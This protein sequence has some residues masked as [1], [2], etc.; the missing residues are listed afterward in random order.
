MTLISGRDLKISDQQFDWMVDRLKDFVAIPS[1]SNPHAVG[2]DMLHLVKASEFAHTLLEGIGFEARSVSI[3]G[4]APFIIG[5]RHVA[6]DKPTVVVYAHYNVQPVD[7]TK[8]DSNPFEMVE[9]NGRYYGRGASDDKAGVLAACAAFKAY[10]EAG[11]E[12]P[13]NVTVLF[14]GEEEYGSGHMEALLKQEAERLR[15]HALIILDGMNRSVDTGTLTSSNRGIVNLTVEIK[16]L[17][18]PVHSGQG[19]L[20]P[21]PAQALTDLITRLKNPREI[22]GM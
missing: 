6:T 13:V 4:S 22:P 18:Q 5:K 10:R 12:L 14:E 1:I 21:D 8:W 11:L 19:L 20:A 2:Y 17:Q 3:E 16:A 9:R 15:G 7:A